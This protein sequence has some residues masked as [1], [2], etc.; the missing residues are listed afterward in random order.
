MPNAQPDLPMSATRE[1]ITPVPIPQHPISQAEPK[2]LKLAHA[3][4]RCSD[5]CKFLT[6]AEHDKL[7]YLESA[8][9]PLHRMQSDLWHE[10]VRLKKL[11]DEV[12]K[13]DRIYMAAIDHLVTRAI[14]RNRIFIPENIGAEN[15]QRSTEQP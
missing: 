12:S 9:I 1:A 6:P 7:A 13:W 8:L 10:F 3:D 2:K 11:S 5:S 15:A 14:T 4:G